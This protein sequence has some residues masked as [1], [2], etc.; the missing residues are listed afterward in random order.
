MSSDTVPTGAGT[1]SEAVVPQG[2]ATI[3]LD[4]VTTNIGQFGVRGS[5]DV[6]GYGGLVTTVTLPGE[7][8]R[9]YGGWFD[10]AA[11][12]LTELLGADYAE[13]VESVVVEFGELTFNVR[14]EHLV[15]F[16]QLLRD[17]PDL[18]FEMCPSVSGVHW[19]GDAGRELH[20]VYHFLSIT[21]SRR[22]RVETT[23]PTTD[24]HVP[25]ITSVYPTADWHERETYD[26]F[27]IIYDGHPGLTRIMMP[28]DWHGHPQ[29]KDYPLGG[30]PVEYKGATIQPPDERRWYA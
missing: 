18:R 9:P 13:V 19:L 10:E 17:D 23:C 2:T 1:G 15:R 25:S 14:R 21:H 30:I 6:S 8:Q 22:L 11:D 16:V 7:S 24:P 4:V 5:P 20:S 12:K 28:D 29:R 3:A 26:F 27:G